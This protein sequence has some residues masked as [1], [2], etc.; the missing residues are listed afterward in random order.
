MKELYEKVFNALNRI[1]L[2][3]KLFSLPVISKLVQYEVFS[4][5]FFGVLT[6]AVNFLV[7]WLCR[8][9]YPDSERVLFSIGSFRIDWSYI[10]NSI[11]WVVAVLFAFVTNKLFVFESRSK[12][13]GV[14][15][16]ELGSFVGARLLSFVL[17]D[18]GMFAL[19]RQ[20][21]MNEYIA[22]IIYSLC[23]IV[24]NYIASKLVIFKTNR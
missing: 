19:L 15:A 23:V 21:G 22:K 10:A 11:A 12:K 4:Y 17:F 13:P 5:L 16:R 6:T 20:L 8:R 2:F 18:W 24:F 1:K 9:L 3:N 7:F 14:V